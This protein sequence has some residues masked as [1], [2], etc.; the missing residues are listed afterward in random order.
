MDS[1]IGLVGS[2]CE[3]NRRTEGRVLHVIHR[4]TLQQ[5][6]GESK[7][8]DSIDDTAS[9]KIRTSREAA[10]RLF[11][12]DTLEITK[13]SVD[14]VQMTPT[15]S[16]MPMHAPPSSLRGYYDPSAYD[17]QTALRNADLSSTVYD[18]FSTNED[19]LALQKKLGDRGFDL[20]AVVDDTIRFSMCSPSAPENILP[21]NAHNCLTA[22]NLNDSPKDAQALI[23]HDRLTGKLIVAIRGTTSVMDLLQ[24]MLFLLPQREVAGGKVHRGFL[25]SYES[26]KPPELSQIKSY[27]ESLQVPPDKILSAMSYGY[28]YPVNRLLPEPG[29]Q[30][31][32]LIHK[33][34]IYLLVK[35]GKFEPGAIATKLRIDASTVAAAVEAISLKRRDDRFFSDQIQSIETELIGISLT[36]HSLGGSVAIVVADDLH[37]NGIPVREVYTYGTPPVGDKAFSRSYDASPL[38]NITY[39]HVAE[40]DLIANAPLFGD[41]YVHVASDQERFL[42]PNGKLWIGLSAEEKKKRF[43]DALSAQPLWATIQAIGRTLGG[44]DID[45]RYVKD[46]TTI[47]NRQIDQRIKNSPVVPTYSS[48]DPFAEFATHPADPFTEDEVREI[49]IDHFGVGEIGRSKSIDSA[50][51][52][53]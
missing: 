18:S 37:R 6:R 44:H 27:L 17:E 36:G 30:Q 29:T 20:L 48:P 50:A 5:A 1:I 52:A 31:L 47:V 26:V 53:A 16:V 32:A 25:G 35:L 21:V 4:K 19:R 45:S 12:D 51:H 24:G 33:M 40:S 38:G 42:D 9:R 34:S 2:W 7:Q 49:L 39:R 15:P 46:L 11:S 14:P 13:D 22:D 8:P 23:A 3:P 10:L 28:N 41:R 43:F